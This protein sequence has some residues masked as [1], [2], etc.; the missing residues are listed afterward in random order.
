MAVLDTATAGQLFGP[1]DVA[2]DPSRARAYATAVGGNE[3][4]DYGDG[5]PPMAI[6][7]AGLTKLINELGLAGGTVH[8]SQE[9]EYF[10]MARAGEHIA[11]SAELKANSVRRGSRFA[12]LFVEYRDA[13]G[14]LVATS[15]STVMVPA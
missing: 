4:P 9:A 11:A 8:L 6:V 7:A 12:T 1:Y 2:I 13:A 14:E 15:S 3:S 5:L 10:R